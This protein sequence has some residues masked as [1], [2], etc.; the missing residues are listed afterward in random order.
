MGLN[1]LG[2][3]G[4]CIGLD[5]DGCAFVS[6]SVFTKRTTIVVYPC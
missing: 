3:W 5:Q 2:D 6:F 1:Y 4:Y